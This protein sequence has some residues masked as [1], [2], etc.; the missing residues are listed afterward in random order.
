MNVIL[1]GIGGLLIG[2]VCGIGVNSKLY[3]FFYYYDVLD[4]IKDKMI[5]FSLMVFVDY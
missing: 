4:G 1:L 3:F 5:Y 2:D